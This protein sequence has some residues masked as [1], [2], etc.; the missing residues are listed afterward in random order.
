MPIKD[1]ELRKIIKIL[2]DKDKDKKAKKKARRKRRRA[3][4]GAS[5]GGGM[6]ATAQIPSTQGVGGP[7]GSLMGGFGG[8]NYWGGGGGGALGPTRQE[9]QNLIQSNLTVPPVPLAQPPLALPPTLASENIFDIP[10]R[11]ILTREEEAVL[12]PAKWTQDI[13]E[14]DTYGNFAGGTGSDAFLAPGEVPVA[15]AFGDDNLTA[16][17]LTENYIPDTFTP[18]GFITSSEAEDVSP[19]KGRN[20]VSDLPA[21]P[22]ESPTKKKRRTPEEIL[23]DEQ[24]KAVKALVKLQK[25]DEAIKAKQAKLEAK[26]TKVPAEPTTSIYKRGKSIPLPSD[27]ESEY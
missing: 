19:V 11:N 24:S 27:Y 20:Y 18:G 16:G 9:I 25:K 8:V 23:A 21:I 13:I 12:E 7:P 26:K 22:E 4:G 2:V 1:E 6:P 14:E 15:T 3:T 17:D 5:S 10:E